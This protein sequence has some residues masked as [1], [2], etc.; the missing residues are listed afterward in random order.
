MLGKFIRNSGGNAA[1]ARIVFHIVALFSD[2]PPSI[3]PLQNGNFKLLTFFLFFFQCD[4]S[5]AGSFSRSAQST[6]FTHT[7][8]M[9]YLIVASDDDF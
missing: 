2:P 1:A 3:N 6:P 8:Y 9:K 7:N 5:A 4:P